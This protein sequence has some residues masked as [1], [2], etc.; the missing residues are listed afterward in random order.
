MLHHAVKNTQSYLASEIPNQHGQPYNIDN[1][2]RNIDAIIRGLA[3]R[4]ITP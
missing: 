3:K 2:L 4:R 1:Q